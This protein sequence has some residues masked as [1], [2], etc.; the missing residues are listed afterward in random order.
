MHFNYASPHFSS[1]K[2]KEL[3]IKDYKKRKEKYCTVE[4]YPYPI[5][6]TYYKSKKLG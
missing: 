4:L 3:N 5:D 2:N 1:T 6:E